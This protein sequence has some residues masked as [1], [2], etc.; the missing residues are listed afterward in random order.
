[1]HFDE[2]LPLPK[3]A[4]KAGFS[5]PAFTRVFK[6]ATGTTFVAYLRSV[7]VDHAKK[8]L[9]TTPLSLEEIA[10][11][12]GFNSQHHLIRS[13]KKVVGQTPGA[14]RKDQATRQGG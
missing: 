8:L 6:K 9:T 12:C 14:Y 5:V 11:S 2:P 10:Q 13:F 3:V 7:R 4:R 1:M